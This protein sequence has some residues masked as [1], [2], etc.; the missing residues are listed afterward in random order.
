MKAK[1]ILALCIA[2]LSVATVR[3]E[4]EPPHDVRSGDT[5]W[6]VS[7]KY[8]NKPTTWPKLWSLN[9]QVHNP[10][11]IFP[12]DD[13]FLEQREFTPA[14]PEMHVIPLVLEKLEPPPPPAPSAAEQEKAKTDAE[15]AKVAQTPKKAFE[16]VENGTL[17]FISSG[18]PDRLGRI[19]NQRVHKIASGEI[20]E[21]EIALA[22]GAR[23]AKGDRVTFFEDKRVIV[24]PVTGRTVGVQVRVLGHGEVLE[25]RDGYARAKVLRSYDF[26]EDGHSVM[27]HR[28]LVHTLEPVPGPGGLESIVLAST[29]E[30][31]LSS[32][33]QVVFLDK[34]AADGLKPGVVMDVPYPRGPE[35]AEGI[36]VGLDKPIARGVVVSAQDKTATLYLL[37]SRKSVKAG[38][39]AVAA[40]DSP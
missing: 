14:E 26:I 34:G 9:P 19:D 22:K 23:V 20:E 21:V 18:K 35:A 31:Q 17:D 8:W 2:G 7:G 11:W 33:D 15:A 16:L 37:E 3:A 32:T 24:H 1:W 28:P 39:R 25:A 27:A 36:T 30:V 6:G 40:S 12:G 38:H 10:H 5:L 4:G 13:L 29:R